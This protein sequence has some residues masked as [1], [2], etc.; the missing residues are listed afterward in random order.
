MHV[1]R[2][3]ILVWCIS[4]STAV[5]WSASQALNCFASDDAT[6][7]DAAPAVDVPMDS[8]ARQYFLPPPI[9]EPMIGPFDDDPSWES[10]QIDR[11]WRGSRE[12][13]IDRITDPTAWLMDF[14]FRQSW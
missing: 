10:S 14:R 5:L 11:P 7:V 12:R 6:P 9:D 3:S 1:P 13:L 8:G 4:V 2:C